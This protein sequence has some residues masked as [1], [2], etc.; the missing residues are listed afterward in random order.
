M[1]PN[2]LPKCWPHLQTGLAEAAA[3]LAAYLPSALA[4]YAP[5]AS[6]VVRLEV[7]VARGVTA[8]RWLAGQELSPAAH[9]VRRQE[10]GR[11]RGEA[12]TG[13]YGTEP[14]RG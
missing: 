13:Q 14:C 10:G 11:E 7:P 9:E 3:A 2:L 5:F 4:K 1:Q 6:G 8:L 12:G